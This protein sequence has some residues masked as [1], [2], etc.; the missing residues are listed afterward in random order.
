MS[1]AAQSE[2]LRVANCSG[3]YGDRASAA[4]EMV[5]GGPI[6]VLTGDWLA[7]LTLLIM[8]KR[9][10]RRPDGGYADTFIRQMEDVLGDCVERD[11]R[12]VANA[13][14]LDPAGCAAALSRLAGAAGIS[15]RVAYVEGDDLLARLAEL[16]EAG[17]PLANVDT[18]EP[19]S[20][21]RGEVVTA[22]AYLGHWGIAEALRQG[23]DVVV[24]GR[25]TDAAL[26]AGPAAWYFGWGAEDLDAL[27]GAV[28]AGHV[29]ECGCQATGG[30]FSFFSEVP[31]LERPGF[32]VAELRGDGSSVITKHPGTG[33]VVNVE[34]VTAQLLY[35]IG[36]PRYL[37][38]DCVARF[39]T[40]ELSSDGPDRVLVTGVRGEPPPSTLRVA[41]NYRG[42][43]RNAVTFVFA[44]LEVPAKVEVAQRALWEL[45]PGGR[46]SFDDVALDVVGSTDADGTAQDLVEL[47]VSVASADEATVGRRFADAAVQTAL[48]SYP[49]CHLASP[50][51]G[52]SEF[53]VLWPTLV[54]RGRVHQSVVMDGVRTAVVDPAVTT[55]ADITSAPSEDGPPG[56]H[57]GSRSGS[58]VTATSGRT[59]LVP[60]GRLCGARSGDKGGNANLGVWARDD[61]VYRWL[62]EYLSVDTLVSL[63]PDAARAQVVRYELANLRAC[64]F[65]LR[66]YLGRGVAASLQRDPQAKNLAERLRAQLGRV[67]AGVLAHAG[68]VVPADVPADVPSNVRR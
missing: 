47:R 36:A 43:Y 13:G 14:G 49:G 15:A 4:R 21:L 66:G 3:F 37:G 65:V 54:E 40:I 60:L 48:A 26:V 50:P 32:P 67:P 17:E 7:E 18:T 68:R 1:A 24:T 8:A 46:A 29:L 20:S 61:V 6:D 42:G 64:N 63:L 23:A 27:A 45:V 31:G 57:G 58:T 41:V 35:E 28:V 33:G 56:I 53:G 9:R 25:V 19:F 12:V 39:D 22:N 2:V 59:G 44:G 10:Q 62:L 38:P 34:T 30:N 52:A 5:D 55:A 51:A 16:Q 11:I